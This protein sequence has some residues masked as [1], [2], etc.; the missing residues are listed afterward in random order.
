MN[1]TALHFY[2]PAFLLGIGSCFLSA[3]IFWEWNTL[4]PEKFLQFNKKKKNSV[5]TDVLPQYKDILLPKE[6][7]GAITSIPL[8]IQGR[9]PIL[10]KANKLTNV[11]ET[12]SVLKLTGVI[13]SSQGFIALVQDDKNTQFRVKNNDLI[14]G[15]KVLTIL[16]ETVTL[17]KQQ[18]I[19]TLQLVDLKENVPSNSTSKNNNDDVFAN[20]VD[21][22]NN[23]SELPPN[24]N[25]LPPE[26]FN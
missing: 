26:L 23:F 1:K 4:N 16:K 8:F 13:S 2:K 25:H 18:Q 14:N 22:Q 9:S 11:V 20:P 12:N 19:Q 24:A 6:N 7:Y 21:I 3:I 5:A 10:E 17:S 15:W